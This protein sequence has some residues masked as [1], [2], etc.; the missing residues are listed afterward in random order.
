MDKTKSAINAFLDPAGIGGGGGMTTDTA[1]SILDP[2]SILGGLRYGGNTPPGRDVIVGEEGPEVL[3]MAPGSTGYV[4]PNPTTLSR[5]MLPGR[6]TGG[7]VGGPVD[8]GDG[9]S[10]GNVTPATP[11]APATPAAPQQA[12]QPPSG[13]LSQGPSNLP[14]G[15]LTQ[16][17]DPRHL[18]QYPGYQFQ[19]QQGQEALQNSQSA[20]IGALSGPALKQLMQFNQGLAANNY[21][22]YFNQFQTQQNNI[23]DRLSSLAQ[24]GQNAASGVG[25]SGTQLGTG[26]AQAEAAAG[27]SMAGGQLGAANAY[28]GAAGNVPLY[29]L[30]ANSMNKP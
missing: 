25:S 21:S 9:K 28:A 3:H 6:F 7:P 15:Y 2:G 12:Q 27:G 23:F 4:T 30:M 16:T 20:T 13:F 19:L 8:G 14:A 1:K 10:L 17:F 5:M 18:A 26:V 29:M 24:L 22:N 11:N